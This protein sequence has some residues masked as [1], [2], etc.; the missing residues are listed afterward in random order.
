MEFTENRQQRLEQEMR[1][2]KV[3]IEKLAK[4]LD[5]YEKNMDDEEFDVMLALMLGTQLKMMAGY[6]DCLV[7]RCNYL[8]FL[9]TVDAV[10]NKED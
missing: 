6:M 10:F 1:D 2:L 9:G 5:E 8:G 3:K 7:M 4:W